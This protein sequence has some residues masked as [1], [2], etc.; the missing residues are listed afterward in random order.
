MVSCSVG[1]FSLSVVYFVG[2]S[3]RIGYRRV[4]VRGLGLLLFWALRVSIL[5]GVVGF[6]GSVLIG[7]VTSA[8]GCFSYGWYFF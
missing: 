5:A 3:Q 7:G 2:F 1:P 8:G 4:C 6:I